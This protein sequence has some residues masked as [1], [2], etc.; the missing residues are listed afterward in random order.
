M[1]PEDLI[2]KVFG[3][4]PAEVND[5]SSPDTIEDWDSLGHLGLLT[6]ITEVYHLELS[7]DDALE[8]VDVASLK[9]IL[10]SRG[11]NW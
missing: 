1:T 3:L 10:S 6:E 9:A 8:I 7:T 11:A 5:E 2:A 4:D